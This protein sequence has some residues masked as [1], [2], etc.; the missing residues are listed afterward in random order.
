MILVMVSIIPIFF[1][2]AYAGTSIFHDS[3]YFN[4]LRK[5]IIL[6]SAISAG[7]ETTHS[8]IYAHKYDPF[9]GLTFFISYN[10]CFF[11]ILQKVFVWVITSTFMKEFKKQLKDEKIENEK[12]NLGKGKKFNYYVYKEF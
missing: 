3:N 4:S 1:G 7:D 5:M 8:M 12:R 9:W 11:I 6:L 10:I 2:F